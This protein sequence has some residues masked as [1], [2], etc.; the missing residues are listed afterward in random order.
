[1]FTFSHEIN[2]TIL[3]NTNESIEDN[4]I[5]LNEYYNVCKNYEI[6][7]NKEQI[8]LLRLLKD[9]GVAFNYGEEGNPHTT[10]ILKPEWV[11]KGIYDIINSNELFKK[12][13][14]VTISEIKEIL[15]D[16]GDYEDKEEVIIGLM[17]QFELCFQ[18]SDE[19]LLVPDLLPEKQPF[20]GSEFNESLQLHYR[21]KYMSRSIMPHFIAR[22]NHM[23]RHI[24]GDKSWYWRSGIIIEK[25]DNK[26][27]IRLNQRKKTLYI[28]VI[29]NEK[30]RRGLLE[31]IRRELDDLHQNIKGDKPDIIVPLPINA[32]YKVNYKLLLQL[33][34]D[35]AEEVFI[36][37]YGHT[38]IAPLLNG[39][40]TKES[41]KVTMDNFKELFVTEQQK[42][43]E[44]KVN[45]IN[46]LIVKNKTKINSFD[47]KLN[48]LNHTEE[49]VKKSA[50]EYATNKDKKLK[51]L[52]VFILLA[53]AGIVIYISF[54]FPSLRFSVPLISVILAIILL[55]CNSLG[56]PYSTKYFYERSQENKFIELCGI[57]GLNLEEINQLE[58]SR[59]EIVVKN[60]ALKTQIQCT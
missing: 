2:H 47:R 56:I 28:S 30:N 10:N 42:E 18:L 23:T 27:L 46:K 44:E 1:M 6:T 13:G 12:G 19:E 60:E 39:I 29:G 7:N 58:K 45:R 14:R 38:K 17:S 37:D 35:G 55:G 11:T 25:D 48:K 24:S 15:S 34:K 5:N 41:R 22:V 9:L 50:K 8:S 16:S 40:E 3:T 36:E 51:R 20:I 4:Y 43:K 54:S 49:K 21:Y 52:I 32:K 33:E 59:L 26:A 31:D 57:S 53:V